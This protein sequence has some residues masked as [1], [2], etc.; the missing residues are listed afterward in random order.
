MAQK[1]IDVIRSESELHAIKN[2]L[3]DNYMQHKLTM[4]KGSCQSKQTSNHGCQQSNHKTLQ[5][6]IVSGNCLYF[7]WSGNCL[8]VCRETV[9]KSCVVKLSCRLIVKFPLNCTRSIE[10]HKQTTF[11]T[12]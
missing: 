12:P 6:P 4:T 11:P 9:S 3:Q 7:C 5:S 8:Q 2:I 10:L 1:I